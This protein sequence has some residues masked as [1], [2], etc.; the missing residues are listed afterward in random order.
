MRNYMEKAI[1]EA[2]IALSEQEIPIGCVIVHDGN[3]IASAHNTKQNSNNSLNHAEMLALNKAM[4][5]LNTKYLYD[6]T[7]YLTIEP[8]AMCAGAM[9]NCRLGK[10]VFGA[11]EPKTGCAVSNYNL[12]NDSRFN[13]RVDV[14]EGILEE[15]CS[16]IMKEFFIIRRNKC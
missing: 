7:M 12:L 2:K 5:V 6:C 15:E 1:E 11:R 8:C 10:L 9:I 3:V 4:E 13:H 14:E 16:N